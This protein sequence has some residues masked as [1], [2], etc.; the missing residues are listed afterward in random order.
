MTEGDSISRHIKIAFLQERPGSGLNDDCRQFIGSAAPDILA[1]PEYY[2]VDFRDESV[3]ASHARREKI[4]LRLKEWSSGFNCILI[5]G[6]LVE[7]V[8][9]R[10]VNRC[11]VFNKGEIVGHY[12][13]IHPYDNE[14]RGLIAPGTEY[15]VFEMDG[16]RIGILICADVL[17]PSSFAN[18]RGL[19]PDLVFAPTTSPYRPNESSSDK[20]DRDMRIFAVGARAAQA[21]I[22]KVSAS[23]SIAGH[24]LQGR[25]LIA[26]PGKIL[27][28]IDPSDEDKPAL[29]IAEL[30]LDLSNPSLDISVHRR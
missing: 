18:L 4:F 12:D 23:G 5:G 20:F 21:F 25:S 8:D 28:R 7:Q 16:L 26:A 19:R 14:G 10:F 13:K 30:G 15:R 1:F 29:V 22:I 27:W 6:S 9:G 11:Y 17:Y 24:P 2:F 3:I